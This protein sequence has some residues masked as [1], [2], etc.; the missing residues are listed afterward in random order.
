MARKKQHETDQA[1]ITNASI[2]FFY[3]VIAAIFIGAFW[4][5]LL[6]LKELIPPSAFPIYRMVMLGTMVACMCWVA[7]MVWLGGADERSEHRARYLAVRTSIAE[8]RLEH[9]YARGIR[10]ILV[11]VDRFFGDAGKPESSLWPNAFGLQQAAPLWTPQSY[12]KCLTIALFYPIAVIFLVWG[13]SGHVGAAESA[14]GLKAADGW[15]RALSLFSMGGMIVSYVLAV[16]L[17]SWKSLV[18]FAFAVAVAFAVAFAVAGAFAVA[19]AGAVAFAGAS[20]FAVAFAFAFAGVVAGAFAV[21]MSMNFARRL[22]RM[23]LALCAFSAVFIVLSLTTP[24]VLP[25]GRASQDMIALV[26]FLTLLTLV[27]TP[28]D[29]FALGVT[30]GLLRRGLERGGAWP[31]WLGIVDL[32]ISIALMGL[33]AITVFWATELFNHFAFLGGYR[34]PVDPAKLLPSLMK[35]PSA[36]EH[37]WLFAMLFSTQIPALLNLVF[38]TFCLMRGIPAINHWMAARLPEKGGLEVWPRLPIASVWS[39][40][41]GLAVAIGCAAFYYLFVYGLVFVLDSVF[42]ITLIELLQSLSIAGWLNG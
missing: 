3:A 8:D 20:A 15:S 14:L 18:A 10:W 19:V 12:D 11:R 5:F 36:Y 39:V 13:W 4:Q 41:M 2:G 21:A 7:L 29:W 40:Q 33:L 37:W 30:R 31:L 25:R 24:L 9:F 23:G 42:G 17:S 28:F 1:G 22:N 6:P 38:G 26:Y 27:N 35:D 16:K 34:A 32:L